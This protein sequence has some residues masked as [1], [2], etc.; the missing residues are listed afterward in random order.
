[1]HKRWNL[2]EFIFVLPVKI[3]NREK[4]SSKDIV[5]PMKSVSINEV[6]SGAA[7]LETITRGTETR[8]SPSK[9]DHNSPMYPMVG[10]IRE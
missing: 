7:F 10:I 4:Y 1:M 6:P 5:N 2:H 8:A 9:E 3:R